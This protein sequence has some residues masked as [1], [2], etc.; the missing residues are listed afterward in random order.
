SC[1]TLCAASGDAGAV[2]AGVAT[3]VFGAVACA[4]AFVAGT[5]SLITGA[6]GAVVTAAV[7]TIGGFGD[8]T[9][10]VGAPFGSRTSGTVPP[11]KSSLAISANNT[12]GSG[13]GEV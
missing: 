2:M 5:P 12:R 13:I 9:I 8:A 10:A 6:S 7:I 3:G 1:G 11:P 4:A